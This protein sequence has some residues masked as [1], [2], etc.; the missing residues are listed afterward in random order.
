MITQVK[1][2]NEMAQ[3][4]WTPTHHGESLDC[5]NRNSMGGVFP[6]VL[7]GV[8]SRNHWFVVVD[9]DRSPDNEK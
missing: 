6:A 2:L 3:R 9:R 5:Y 4:G 1:G 8:S 7:C